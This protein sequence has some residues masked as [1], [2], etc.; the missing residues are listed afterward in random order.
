MIMLKILILVM[1]QEDA[2]NIIEPVSKEIYQ[3]LYL[4]MGDYAVKVLIDTNNNG[5][6]DL[7]FFGLPKEQFD[8][9]IM[10]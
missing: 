8:F 7:N 6:I 2:Y 9:Q 5:D 3:K 4:K 1:T 10:F